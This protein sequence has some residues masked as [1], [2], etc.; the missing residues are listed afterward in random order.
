MGILVQ[1]LVKDLDEALILEGIGADIDLMPE[2]CTLTQDEEEPSIWHWHLPL[3]AKDVPL[4]VYFYVDQ[5]M[6]LLYTLIFQGEKDHETTDEEQ[7]VIEEC[8]EWL[9][10][11]GE[12]NVQKTKQS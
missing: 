3:Y 12:F 8:F 9:F 7:V 10:I 5:G 6:T 4:T 11:E 2:G 1:Q